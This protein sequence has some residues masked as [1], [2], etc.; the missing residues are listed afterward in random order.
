MNTNQTHM[1]PKQKQIKTQH[2][3]IKSKT[4]HIANIS[5]SSKKQPKDQ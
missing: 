1:K 2:K 4:K 5:T 3:T